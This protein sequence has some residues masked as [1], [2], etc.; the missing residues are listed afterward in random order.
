MTIRARLTGWYAGILLVSLALMTWVLKY[1]W[2]EQQ[3]LRAAGKAAEPA[4]EEVGEIVLYHGVPTALLLLAGGWLLL[5]KSLAPVTALTRAAERIDLDNLKER[6]PRSGNRDELDRLTGVFNTMIERLE[7]SFLRV[8]E[9]TLHASHELKTPLTVMR[10][11]IES[12]LRDDTWT[13]AQREIFCNQLEE[14]QRLTKI[15]D[16]LTTLAKAD[17]GHIAL[18]SEPVRLDQLVRDS[19]ADAQI[20]AEPS[21]IKVDLAVCDEI[22]VWGDRHRLR[23]LLLNLT[24]NAIKYNQPDGKVTVGL[25]RNNG[26]AELTIINTGEGIV[27]EKLPR[28]FDRFFRGDPAHSNNVE[29]SGLGLSIAQ[30]IARAHAGEISIT[31]RPHSLT[32]VTVQLP[33]GTPDNAK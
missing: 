24:D 15:V 31:S 18:N 21:R 9:F 20:L 12:T 29:G 10:A 28:V 13:A 25:R 30:W 1:E 33:A 19:F 3:Q 32:T 4:W 7:G 22:T 16:G 11:E 2:D 8:R 6:L 23:Q 5:R 26:K 14:I 17:A 27:P